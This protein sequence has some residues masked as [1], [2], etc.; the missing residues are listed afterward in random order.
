VHLSGA[1]GT[2]GAGL[3]T[4]VGTLG[5]VTTRSRWLLLL[6]LGL[7]LAVIAALTLA[8]HVLDGRKHIDLTG[9]L[10]GGRV[11]TDELCSAELPCNQAVTSGT[12]TMYRFDEQEQAVAAAREFAGEAY[13]SGWIVVRF[14]PGALTVEQRR[15]VALFLDCTNVGV[16]DDG[17]EC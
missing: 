16:T 13:L 1:P 8:P 2:D 7:P 12:H 15:E 6:A 14:E 10:P 11:A 4:L 9:V 5:G 17:V 3:R